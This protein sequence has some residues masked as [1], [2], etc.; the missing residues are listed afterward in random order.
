MSSDCGTGSRSVLEWRVPLR[1]LCTQEEELRRSPGLFL[2]SRGPGEGAQITPGKKPDKRRKPDASADLSDRAVQ[3]PGAG[4]RGPQKQLRHD[5]KQQGGAR[6]PQTRTEQRTERQSDQSR[7]R[8][9]RRRSR[10]QKGKYRAHRASDRRRSRNRE[11]QDPAAEP[12]EPEGEALSLD[13]IDD[14][15]L[16]GD[17]DPDEEQQSQRWRITDDALAPLSMDLLQSSASQIRART[18]SDAPPAGQ[19][20]RQ[21]APQQQGGGNGQPR[22]QSAKNG[23]QSA[24]RKRQEEPHVRSFSFR[25]MQKSKNMKKFRRSY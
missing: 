20:G 7:A 24:Q 14:L 13:S 16:P 4:K 18:H 17:V 2:R 15:V 19:N 6:T 3:E 22:Q 5:C 9:P 21:N 11:A 8:I 12:A 25:K 1:F 23:S 10:P